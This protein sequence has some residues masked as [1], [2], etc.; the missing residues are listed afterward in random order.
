MKYIHKKMGISKFFT[1]FAPQHMLKKDFENFKGTTIAIDGSGE[2]HRA[3][4]GMQKMNHLTSQT[5]ER[6]QHVNIILANILKRRRN[7]I[8]E[9][10]VFDNPQVSIHK[11]DEVERRRENRAKAEA[12]RDILIEL[13]D[14]AT[15]EE[16]TKISQYEKAAASVDDADFAKIKLL[17]N[18]FGI[19]WL[20]APPNV[21]AEQICALLTHT[22]CEYVLTGDSDTLIYG[23]KK[24]IIRTS[25]GGVM[26]YELDT[27]LKENDLTLHE[28][29]IIAVLLGT[30]HN[31]KGRKGIGPKKVMKVYKTAV[32]TEEESAVLRIFEDPLDFTPKWNTSPPDQDGL[33]EWL[34]GDL[35]FNR[36]RVTKLLSKDSKSKK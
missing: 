7:G 8:S 5:G 4:K 17:L 6:T 28:L 32:L 21:E 24:V 26:V 10:W 27:L 25:D 1:L 14:L 15:D 23:A 16:M 34:V 36:D 18:Y 9:Y 29:R 35:S 3:L 13:A 11:T 30:D 33:I 20:E 12:K 19:P 22:I 2:V 31:R